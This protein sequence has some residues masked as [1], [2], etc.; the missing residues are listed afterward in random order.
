[1]RKSK[2]YGRLASL[3]RDREMVTDIKMGM[4]KSIVVPT[5]LYGSEYFEAVWS[6]G[7]DE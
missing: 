1:M 4:L 3:W 5:V 7:E 2:N 6:Y